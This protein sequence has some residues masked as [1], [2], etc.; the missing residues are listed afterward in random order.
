MKLQAER[1][2]LL[3]RIQDQSADLNKAALRRERDVQSFD[4]FSEVSRSTSHSRGGNGSGK[5]LREHIAPGL[6]VRLP[7]KPDYDTGEPTS[8]RD[9]DAQIHLEAMQRRNLELER[10]LRE[11]NSDVSTVRS[12]EE[13]AK[14]ELDRL[15]EVVKRQQ[16]MILQQKHMLQQEENRRVA[17]MEEVAGLK[18]ELNHA[19]LHSPKGNRPDIYMIPQPIPEDNSCPAPPAPP[20]TPMLPEPEPSPAKHN[21]EKLNNLLAE[22]RTLAKKKP[23]PKATPP[24][25]APIDEPHRSPRHVIR[26]DSKVKRL[27]PSSDDE[28]VLFEGSGT[29]SGTM[30]TQHPQAS[31]ACA[32]DCKIM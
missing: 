31:P 5:L 2:A 21:P 25:A 17:M 9:A 30:V 14:E 3:E 7:F 20:C 32:A 19:L 18:V 24:P 11:R 22:A 26:K 4:T 29:T 28:R 8:L 27:D 16:D 23:I 6:G 12:D 10:Q 1:D 13:A 15:Q